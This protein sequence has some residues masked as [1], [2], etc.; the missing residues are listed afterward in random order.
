MAIQLYVTVDAVK[1]G[2]FKGEGLAGDRG[3]IPGVGL[4]Y[5][6]N[7]PRDPF[8]GQASGKRQHKPVVFTKEWGISSPQFYSALFTNEVLK[9][10]VFE[11]IGTTS[12]GEEVDHT[13]K[14]TNAAISGVRQYVH[15]GPSGGPAV[16]TRELQ[17]VT[18]TFQKI[19]IESETGKTT[20][21]DEWQT[22][23]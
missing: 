6:A 8:S 12:R 16:D 1:Q 19:E 4:E 14:L 13:I 7:A 3:R 23:G 21:T 5:E 17:E 18:F 11:F 22:S 9:S 15:N 2:K 10:V 20:A